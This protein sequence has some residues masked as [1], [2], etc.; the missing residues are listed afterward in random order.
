M[1]DFAN[2]VRELGG[3]YKAAAALGISRPAVQRRLRRERKAERGELGF[4]PVLP[5]FAIKSTAG[6]VG[7][8]WVKQTKAHGEVFAMPEGQ[9]L[10]E[11][12][13][14]V[15]ESDRVVLK[16]VK[17][18]ESQAPIATEAIKAAFAEYT[19]RAE[20]VAEPVYCDAELAT[21]YMLADHHLGLLAWK[22]ESGASYDLKIASEL[23]ISKMRALVRAA[24][25]SALAVILNL[26]DFTH[27][28]NSS[29]T[30]GRSGNALDVDGRYAKILSV[31]VKLLITV[32]EEALTKHARV[33]YRGLPG[34]H[35]PH[36]ALALTLALSMFFE[37]NTR[38]E[39][40]CDPSKFFCYQHGK[41][42]LTATHGDMLKPQ[43][44]ALYAAER[45]PDAWGA[46]RS[47]YGH[48]GHV[49]HSAKG[50]REGGLQWES[51]ETLTAKDAWHAGEGYQ[52]PR[53]FS[54]VTYHNETGE[55]MRNRVSVN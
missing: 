11:L 19:G 30:T 12:S 50:G 23:L 27:A 43:G 3:Q 24:P 16:W 46:T 7:D 26:G 31:G 36:T 44:M 47:R 32:I 33:I 34:N 2:Q 42:L 51:W 1:N 48:F 54:A 55:F 28:D 14:L 9:Q 22:P 4:A 15:D 45:W 13:A 53:S 18:K 6:K 10:K 37:G 39:I 17:T 38:V 35:D 21:A 8:I 41:T 29:N 49:H 5:G 20:I 25:S 52:S 40:D